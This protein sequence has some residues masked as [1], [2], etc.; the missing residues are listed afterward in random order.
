MLCGRAHLFFVALEDF[1]TVSVVN[2]ACF[3]FI[4]LQ[5]ELNEG[6]E[7][8]NVSIEPIPGVILVEGGMA[9]IVI[10]DATGKTTYYRDNMLG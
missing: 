2:R 6:M 9:V 10:L 5:D 8:F 3:T 7:T 4:A 1:V